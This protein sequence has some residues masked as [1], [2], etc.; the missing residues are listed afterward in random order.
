MVCWEPVLLV[1]LYLRTSCISF[2]CEGI[3]T[4]HSAWQFFPFSTW[5]VLCCFLLTFMISAEKSAVIQIVFPSTGKYYCS[6]VVFKIFFLCFWF[7]PV[8]LLYYFLRISL[9]LFCSRFA[10]SLK[11]ASVCLLPKFESFSCYFFE[12]FFSTILLLFFQDS[13]DMNN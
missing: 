3:F 11:L 8:W 5:N 4:G 10:Q 7:L 9:G 6:L 12:Y 13:D 2:I 1:V